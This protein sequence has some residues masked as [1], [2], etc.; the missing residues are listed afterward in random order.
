[1]AQ[2]RGENRQWTPPENDVKDIIKR[3]NQH[4]GRDDGVEQ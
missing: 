1:M 3:T 4:D 2:K